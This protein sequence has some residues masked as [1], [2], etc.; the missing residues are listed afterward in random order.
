MLPD[1]PLLTTRLVSI[2]F[3]FLECLA[4]I[5]VFSAGSPI[6]SPSVTDLLKSLAGR[7]LRLPELTALEPL[8]FRIGMALLQP[9]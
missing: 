8:H 5:L 6:T 1:K 9:A 3:V 4:R 2:A 7:L